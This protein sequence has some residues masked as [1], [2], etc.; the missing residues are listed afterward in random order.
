MWFGQGESNFNLQREYEQIPDNPLTFTSYY[1]Y[2]FIIDELLLITT[3]AKQAFAKGKPGQPREAG[4]SMNTLDWFAQ[5]LLAGVF[6]IDGC[7]RIFVCSQQAESRSSGA[8]KDGIAMPLGAACAVGLV[9]IAGATGL[10]VPVHAWQP[11]IVP[12]L[13]TAVLLI[14]AGASLIYH[15]QR[16]QPAAPVVAVFLLVLFAIIGRW[17]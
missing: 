10:V 15:I 16:R 8:G 14:L 5:I 11:D 7:R 3:D 1:P 4:K 13:A 6:L 12:M 2:I 17:A 9:E